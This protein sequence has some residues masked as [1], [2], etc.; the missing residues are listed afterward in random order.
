MLPPERETFLRWEKL[1]IKGGTNE[2]DYDLD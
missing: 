1:R 2:S